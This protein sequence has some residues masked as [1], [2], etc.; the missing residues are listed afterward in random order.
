MNKKYLLKNTDYKKILKY[1]N[2][3]IPKNISKI[4]SAAEK[5]LANK[6]CGCIKKVEKYSKSRKE[7]RGIGICR[8]SVI[9]RKKL[10]FKQFTCKKTPSF[11]GKTGHKLKKTVKNIKYGNK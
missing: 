9:T 2:K 10:V 1:Y 11:K 5:I 6:L 7:R 8:K 4:R 3:P